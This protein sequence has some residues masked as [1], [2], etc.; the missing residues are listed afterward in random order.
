MSSALL[1][2]KLAE[3]GLSVLGPTQLG[4]IGDESPKTIGHG[5]PIR[6]AGDVSLGVKWRALDQD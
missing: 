1:D 4:D 3:L 5:L 2:E 6:V